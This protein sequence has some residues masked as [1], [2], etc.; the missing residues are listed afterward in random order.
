MISEY[1]RQFLR[2]PRSSLDEQDEVAHSRPETTTGVLL[3]ALQRSFKVKPA[4]TIG[5]SLEEEKIRRSATRDRSNTARVRSTVSV[6]GSQMRTANRCRR[7]SR[8]IEDD[9]DLVDIDP[10]RRCWARAQVAGRR[11]GRNW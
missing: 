6:G 7:R 9:V 8:E 2:P 5:R 11:D 3:H 10:G 1:A 4:T